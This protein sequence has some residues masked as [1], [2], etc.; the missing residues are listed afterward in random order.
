MSK[1]I[2][3]KNVSGTRRFVNINNISEIVDIDQG[4]SCLVYLNGDN[5]F[6]TIKSYDEIV[7]I[8]KQKE[9][10]GEGMMA[11]Y[12]KRTDV[13]KICE[14]Y[15]RHCF[16]SNDS[17]GQD[18]ADRI[19]DD[20]VEIPT[21]DVVEVKHGEWKLHPDGSGTCSYCNRI[22]KSVWDFDNAQNF[23]GHCGADMRGEEK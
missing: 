23:C 16:L 3:L 11:E 18:I 15:S 14:G 4:Y 10:G 19:L 8:I 12:I 2:E 6:K 13:M 5:Y 1:F 22:Q 17:N 9:R 7:A 20:V 21:V